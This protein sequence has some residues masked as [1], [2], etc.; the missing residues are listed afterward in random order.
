MNTLFLNDLAEAHVVVKNYKAMGYRAKVVVS[1][2][3]NFS[4]YMFTVIVEKA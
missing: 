4:A 2:V 3:H 1:D